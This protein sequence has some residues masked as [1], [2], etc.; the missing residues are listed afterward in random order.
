MNEPWSQL[1]KKLPLSRTEREVVKRYESDPSG[2]TFL[3]IADILRSHKLGDESL[4][5]LTQGVER[6][7]NFTVARVVLARELLNKGLILDAWRNLEDSPI[8]LKDNLLAQKLRFRL[9][10]LLNNEEVCRS[11]YKHL[12]V[13]QMLDADLNRIGDVMEISGFAKARLRLIKDLKERGTEP[14]LPEEIN[15]F[16]VPDAPMPEASLVERAGAL[17]TDFLSKE[18]LEEVEDLD[19]FHVVPLREIFAPGDEITGKKSADDGVELDSTTLADIYTKQGHYSKALSVYRRLLKMTP[20]NDMIKRKVAE[21]ARLDKDQ[22]DIDL[23][24]DPAIVDKMESVEIIDKQIN[25]YNSL[26][27]RLS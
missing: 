22:R 7:P 14:V 15:A 26:L 8:T 23:S 21:L 25:F 9:S 18:F 11:T 2:R 13:F 12:K 5:L 10:L 24:V 1:L 20:G 4:E 16:E 3:P 6:H 19:G 27:G 17:T